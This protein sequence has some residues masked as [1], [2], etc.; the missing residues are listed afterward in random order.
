MTMKTPDHVT[1]REA[2]H[3]TPATE[4]DAPRVFVQGMEIEIPA[5][6]TPAESRMEWRREFVASALMAREEVEQFGLVY[7]ADEVFSYFRAKLEGRPAQHP[8]LVKL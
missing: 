6:K 5:S 8:K 7:E 4:D 3:S 1:P 2:C